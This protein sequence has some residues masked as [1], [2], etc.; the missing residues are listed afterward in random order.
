M[1]TLLAITLALGLAGCGSPSGP[2]GEET[3]PPE[4]KT[5]HKK[6]AKG[7]EEIVTTIPEQ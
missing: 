7:N 2:T 1:R 6:D 5:Q 3:P 4:P